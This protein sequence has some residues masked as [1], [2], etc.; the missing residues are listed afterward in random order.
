MTRV[1]V[2]PLDRADAAAL[3]DAAGLPAELSERVHA[4]TGGHPLFI[5]ETLRDWREHGVPVGERLMAPGVREAIRRRLAG[6]DPACVEAAGAAAV[7]GTRFDP[8]LVALVT[9]RDELES[10]R[11]ALE[12]SAPFDDGYTPIT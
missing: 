12:R 11:A 7:L 8:G 10:L 3:L 1:P 2:G 9:D 4:E 6:L 5:V